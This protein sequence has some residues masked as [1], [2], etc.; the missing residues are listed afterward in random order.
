MPSPTPSPP[1]AKR[2]ALRQRGTL[3]PHPAAVTDALFRDRAFFDPHDLVQVKYEMVRRVA[4]DR[5]AVTHVAAAFGV[6][7]PTFYQAQRAVAAGGL[8]GLIPRKRGPRTAHKLTP[9]VQA[10]LQQQRTANPAVRAATLA[11]HVHGQFGVR[12]HPRT[13]ERHLQGAKKKRR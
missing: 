7:R 11:T 9:A 1:A 13:I 5:Q 3:H 6:S 2:D 4:I 8:G 12:V 10:F